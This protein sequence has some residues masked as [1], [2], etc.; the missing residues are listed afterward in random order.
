MES[1]WERMSAHPSLP[2][3]HPHI[4]S[5][6][7]LSSQ[8]TEVPEVVEERQVP[9]SQPLPAER[10]C[11]ALSHMLPVPQSAQKVPAGSTCWHE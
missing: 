11:S 2:T 3:T 10:E 5:C 7:V 6:P 1:V 8:P 4:K 9:H